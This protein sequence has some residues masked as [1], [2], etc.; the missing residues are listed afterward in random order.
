MSE[1][2]PEYVWAF[3]EEK[4]K[5]GRVWLIVVLSVAALLIAAFVFWMF[6][7][8][9]VPDAV[10][11]PAPTLSASASPSPSAT[12]S[13]TSTPT[14]TPTATPTSVPT[15][16][17]TTPAPPKPVDPN[18]ATFRAKVAPVL[19]DARTGLQIAA[20]SDAQE[21]TQNVGFLQE[22]AGRMADYIAPGSIAAQWNSR[23]TDYSRSLQNL[24]TAYEK[25]G[26]ANSELAAAKAALTAL[27]KVV[28]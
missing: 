19:D 1:P 3:P 17:P 16:V 10:A 7:R 4:P 26:P 23:L 20:E 6:V 27:N 12:P 5:R 8:P 24:R 9:S 28:D 13:A 25:G 22:D 11:T 14:P 18:V 21:A 2:Q 15:T